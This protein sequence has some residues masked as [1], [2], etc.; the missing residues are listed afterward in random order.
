MN[1]DWDFAGAQPQQVMP[2]LGAK[3]YEKAYNLSISGR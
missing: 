1:R 2:T 3:K